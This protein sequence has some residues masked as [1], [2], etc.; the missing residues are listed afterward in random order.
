MI[1]T[2]PAVP[3]P[4]ALKLGLLFG[5]MAIGLCAA[6]WTMAS[7][8]ALEP[9]SDF[10]SLGLLSAAILLAFVFLFWRLWPLDRCL[11][12]LRAGGRPALDVSKAA[13][14]SM[15]LGISIQIA[16]LI[17]SLALGV[18]LMVSDIGI[19]SDPQKIAGLLA[20]AVVPLLSAGLISAVLTGRLLRP[21]WVALA[22]P[23]VVVRWRFG[24]ASRLTLSMVSLVLV[25]LAVVVWIGE[26]ARVRLVQPGEQVHVDALGGEGSG[27]APVLVVAI[28]MVCLSVLVA[29]LFSSGIRRRSLELSTRLD[30]MARSKDGE[31]L[32]PLP[33]VSATES[34]SIALAFNRLLEV[35]KA[36]KDKLIEY[37][38]QVSRS[39]K[40]RKRF[41]RN[42]SHELRTPLNSIIGFSDL[43]ERNLD[44][45]LNPGQRK[46]VEVI[47][48]S[49]DHLL[50]QINDVLLMAQFEAGRAVA[51]TERVTMADLEEAARES[52]G[53]S[54][55]SKRVLGLDSS[56]EQIQIEVDLSLMVRAIQAL[57]DCQTTASDPLLG[58]EHNGRDG[59]PRIVIRTPM[60]E[61]LL[62]ER[63]EESLFQGF[64]SAGGESDTEPG[65]GLGL[66]LAKRVA[67]LHG[68]DVRRMVK[69]T[70]CWVELSIP[71][72][73]SQGLESE[74]VV[75]AT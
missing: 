71:I 47:S 48:R 8:V 7:A 62:C 24:L 72:A 70:Q 73:K 6:F 40:T 32:T 26:R 12:I 74:S 37:T 29:W 66:P 64:R 45:E 20:S 15:S 50:V 38:A 19:Q 52:L 11:T 67:L 41:L 69:D 34:G 60:S 51:Q 30:E 25:G 57:V 18:G 56:L 31:P 43:L 46:A 2:R 58:V 61:S 65:I 55:S 28:G 16:A 39:E 22:L 3:G 21:A 75:G 10:R 68:G 59:D 27:L 13:A 9:L 4:T 23:E 42:V 54:D 53:L 17:C 33:V 63:S 44:G 49:G 5:L 35:D 1:G 14:E 36:Q